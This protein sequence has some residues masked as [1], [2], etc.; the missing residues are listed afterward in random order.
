M[1][2]FLISEPL[3]GSVFNPTQIRWPVITVAGERHF[4]T[5]VLEETGKS[6]TNK[7]AYEWSVEHCR[8]RAFCPSLSQVLALYLHWCYHWLWLQ[9][10]AAHQSL[11]YQTSYHS[12]DADRSPNRR[13]NRPNSS[14][15]V[16]WRLRTTR[17]L[18]TLPLTRR[19]SQEWWSHRGLKFR[20]FDGLS[21]SWVLVLIGAFVTFDWG[22]VAI[23]LQRV[24]SETRL[25]AKLLPSFTGLSWL[26]RLMG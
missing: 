10:L 21:W 1:V 8:L 18:Q 12:A 5:P 26:F 25:S 9:K 24:S 11:W 15:L 7:E 23:K 22:D 20:T 4:N 2:C 17:R 3:L 6:P 14:N 16:W 19:Q 13:E